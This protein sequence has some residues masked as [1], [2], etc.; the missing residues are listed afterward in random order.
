MTLDLEERV[1]TIEAA[2]RLLTAIL[3]RQQEQ[4]QIQNERLE[5]TRRDTQSGS[6]DRGADQGRP[7]P[8]SGTSSMSP[9]RCR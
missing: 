8:I 5:E 9:R 2:I 6:A 1:P 3:E 4:L 7:E